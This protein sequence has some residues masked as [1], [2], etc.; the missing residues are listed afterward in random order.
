AGPE[1]QPPPFPPKPPTAFVVHLLHRLREYG[2]DASALRRL[3]DE[4]L[5]LHDLTSEDAIRAEHQEQATA[6]AAVSNSITSLRLC[7]SL[8][9]SLYFERVSPVE[10]V[11]QRDP[12][13][14]YKRMD[15]ATRDRYRQ[16]VEEL[17][18]PSGE[19]QARVALR[20]IESAIE[21]G[22]SVTHEART[23]HVGYHLLGKGRAKLEVDVAY[24][25]RATQ[26]IT[27]FLFK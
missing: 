20:A 12:A 2:A 15:F 13:G 19:A 16:A 21:A 3:L 17:A 11:L 24:V 8:D 1:G 25:P 10:Q 23:R 22:E 26:R 27:D 6:L 7:S 5:A 4:Q 18:E 14:I 9:W